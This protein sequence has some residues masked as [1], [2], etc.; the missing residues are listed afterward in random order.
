MSQRQTRAEKQ[1]TE[2]LFWLKTNAFTDCGDSKI[3]W[4]GERWNDD[5]DDDDDDD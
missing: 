4:W 5:D 2:C 1:Y 3:M